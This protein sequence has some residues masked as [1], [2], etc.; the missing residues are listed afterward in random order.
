MNNDKDDEGEVLGPVH[1]FEIDN[2]NETYSA[3]L[4]LHLNEER[5]SQSFVTLL[6]KEF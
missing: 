3:I 5:L 4:D 1:N 2:D 6:S